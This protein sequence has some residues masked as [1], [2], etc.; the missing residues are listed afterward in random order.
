MISSDSSA[1]RSADTLPPDSMKRVADA[2]ES[3][4]IQFTEHKCKGETRKKK[5]KRNE[6]EWWRHRAK[7]STP[8]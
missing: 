1:I 2:Q 6:K 4:R 3:L 5:Q 7:R 8:I